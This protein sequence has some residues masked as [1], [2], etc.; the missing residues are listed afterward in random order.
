L[1]T[2]S[3]AV[4]LTPLF[5]LRARNASLLR[6]HA[7]LALFGARSAFTRP[8]TAWSQGLNADD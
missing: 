4:E 6:P 2:G 7:L 8:V 5:P 1:E 3:L